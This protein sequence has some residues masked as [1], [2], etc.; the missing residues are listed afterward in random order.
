MQNLAAGQR[1]GELADLLHQTPPDQ[2]RV[3]GQ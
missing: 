1:L 3:V 2:V